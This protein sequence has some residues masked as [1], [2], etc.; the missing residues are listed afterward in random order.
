MIENN[1]LGEKTRQGFY[2]KGKDIEGKK[3]ILSLDY[4]T[5]KYS[6][7]GKVRLA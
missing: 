2:K 5:L 6:P 4:T 1:M 3:V 7:Q